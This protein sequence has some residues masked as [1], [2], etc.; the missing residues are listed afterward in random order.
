VDALADPPGGTN[1]FDQTI[2]IYMTEGAV[3]DLGTRNKL[4]SV[5][6]GGGDATGGNVEVTYNYSN[7]NSFTVTHP[8]DPA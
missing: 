5:T 1:L 3:F 4:S 8:Q 2:L 7:F 6:Y